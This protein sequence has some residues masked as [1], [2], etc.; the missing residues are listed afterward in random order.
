MTTHT[1]VNENASRPEIT[2]SVEASG[3]PMIH[4]HS[5]NTPD[6]ESARSVRSRSPLSMVVQR[7]RLIAP[8]GGIAARNGVRQYSTHTG[9]RLVMLVVRAMAATI[10]TR[11]VGIDPCRWPNLSTSLPSSGL[12][13]ASAIAWMAVST[14]AS[15]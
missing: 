7:A 14:P 10:Q 12:E 1:P 2:A 13:T 9:A 8:H 15:E 3:L 4:M 6:S 11:I 5:S